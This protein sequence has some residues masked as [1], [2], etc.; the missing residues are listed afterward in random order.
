VP[1]EHL[2]VARIDG[3]NFTKLT[4][5]KHNF[6]T[7]FDERFRDYMIAT[8]KHLM[9]C[10]FRVIYGYTQSDEISLLFQAQEN[11][12]G[13][14]VRKYNSV[15][16]GE[17]SA[18]FSL[19]L[20]DLACFDC[21]ISELPDRE[22][23]KDYFRWRNEDA[24]RNSLNAHCYWTQRKA[25][26]SVAEATQFISRMATHEKRELLFSFGINFDE[27]DNWRKRGVGLLW[28][29]ENIVDGTRLQNKKHLRSD[30]VSN[31]N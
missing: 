2:I 13:R 1:P 5:E 30:G 8:T 3:R 17:A 26:H 28:G 23:V 19:L 22:S 29:V 15:M 12:F 20:G 16:A 31:R 25:G 18:K 14:K 21:R 24:C 11:S 9:S 6:E 10:G 7:P 27:L 4:K